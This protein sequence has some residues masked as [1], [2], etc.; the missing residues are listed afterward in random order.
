MRNV[1]LACALVLCTSAGCSPSYTP[2]EYATVGHRAPVPANA[3]A[4]AP[5]RN[6]RVR[7]AAA[8]RRPAPA[9]AVA[10]PAEASQPGAPRADAGPRSSAQGS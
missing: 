3:A 7:A 2:G 4:A 6:R 10:M 9:P 5:A 8:R 1:L